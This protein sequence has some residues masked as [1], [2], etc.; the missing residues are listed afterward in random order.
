MVNVISRRGADGDDGYTRGLRTSVR[1]G[2]RTAACQHPS[3]APISPAHTQM[4]ASNGPASC[5]IFSTQ[6]P[7]SSVFP[8][9]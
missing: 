2:P 5:I 6:S 8:S 9:P 3:R 4:R 7:S 1:L